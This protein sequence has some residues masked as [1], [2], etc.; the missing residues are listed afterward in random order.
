MSRSPQ[1]KA[2]RRLML[3]QRKEAVR[4]AQ[5]ETPDAKAEAAPEPQPNPAPQP[6]PEPQPKPAQAQPSGRRNVRAR[7]IEILWATVDRYQRELQTD[8]ERLTITATQAIRCLERIDQIEQE[9]AAL[10]ESRQRQEEVRRLQEEEK[11]LPAWARTPIPDWKLPQSAVHRLARR[12]LER[13]AAD[14]PRAA[15]PEPVV[16]GFESPAPATG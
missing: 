6:K 5:A 16:T 13:L 4:A 1:G 10:E 11:S 2:Q 8:K 14:T 12:E 15:P 3:A 9:E 7:M